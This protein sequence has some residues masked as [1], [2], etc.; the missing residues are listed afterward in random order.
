MGIY[1]PI[2]CRNT[3]LCT[4]LLWRK[5]IKPDKYLNEQSDTSW[6]CPI[7]GSYNILLQDLYACILFRCTF[8][9]WCSMVRCEV[10]MATTIIIRLL[11]LGF[12]A[13]YLENYQHFGGKCWLRFWSK[14]IFFFLKS[15]ISGSSKNSGGYYQ[16][17]RR[18][19]LQCGLRQGWRNIGAIA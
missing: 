13:V 14:R 2:L 17:T 18:H 4:P 6:S 1:L 9:T 5:Q 12:D 11:L 7:P 15:G 8:T 3:L 16:T 19:N 10:L